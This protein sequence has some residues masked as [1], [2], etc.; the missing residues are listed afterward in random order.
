M[1]VPH[2]VPPHFDYLCERSAPV[3]HP[4]ERASF[5][6]E[7]S[8]RKTLRACTEGWMCG[9]ADCPRCGERAAR[10]AQRDALA[11]FA[12]FPHCISLRLSVDMNADLDAGRRDLDRVRTTFLKTSHLRATAHAYLRSTEVTRPDARWNWHDHLVVIPR[13]D[14]DAEISR[15][16]DAWDDACRTHGLTA[17]TH[18]RIS[19]TP[20]ALKYI[21]KER[22]GTDEGSLRHLIDRAA[23]GDADAAD[24]FTEWD[25]WRRAHPRARFRSSWVAPVTTTPEQKVP[26]PPRDQ[27]IVNA[28]DADLARM[29]ILS[30][31]GLTSKTEQADAL[32]V[33]PATIA[34][35]RRHFPAPRPGFIPVRRTLTPSTR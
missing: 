25:A 14:P 8:T 33:S 31:L 2:A 7:F 10:R 32:G 23:R 35:R 28:E 16:L 34:R 29:A 11:R 6:A 26:T 12:E 20:A 21:L 9:L 27:H 4:H 17:S 1:S 5:V 15:L 3:T 24:D 13:G 19:S 30:A 18:D 22:L